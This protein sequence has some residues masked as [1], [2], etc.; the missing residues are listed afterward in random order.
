MKQLFVEKTII[1]LLIREH[2][3]FFVGNELFNFSGHP[4]RITVFANFSFM[5]YI[6][7]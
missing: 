3:L 1:P 7:I 2:S 4:R 5:W 6:V